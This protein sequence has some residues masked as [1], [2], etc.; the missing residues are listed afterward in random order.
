LGR[1]NFF[2][3]NEVAKGD[4]L[5]EADKSYN[6]QVKK[7]GKNKVLRKDGISKYSHLFIDTRLQ[8][9]IDKLNKKNK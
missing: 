5:T 4:K 1:Y 9:D 6:R 3:K 8:A 7:H 2:Y